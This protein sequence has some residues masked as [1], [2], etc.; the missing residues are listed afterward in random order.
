MQNILLVSHCVLNTSSKVVLYNKDE[1][2]AEEALRRKFLA[3]AIEKGV[4]FLQLPCPEFTL[5]G[6]C[7]WGHVSTQ[8]DNPFFRN[9]CYKQLDPVFLQLKEYLAHKERFHVIGI[10]GIDG[11]P[12]CGVDYTFAGPW[13]GSFGGREDLEDTLNSV[14]CKHGKGVL[15]DVIQ[16]RLEEEGLE[17]EVPVIGLF[18]TEEEK[19]MSLLENL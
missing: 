8:F 9:H 16:K 4:Q 10:L 19:C 13:G 5:Y 7:R 1:I 17:K 2:E 18:A 6:A 15:M 14:T 3:K 12:S 11:S